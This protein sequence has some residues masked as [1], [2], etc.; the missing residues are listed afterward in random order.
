MERNGV[1]KSKNVI[2]FWAIPVEDEII[3]LKNIIKSLSE[4]L[5]T[6]IFLPHITIY[7][8][9]CKASKA[10]TIIDNISTNYNAFNIKVKR[11]DYSDEITK[12]LYIDFYES[13]SLTRIYNFIKA[14]LITS[15]D[16]LLSPH[17]SLVYKKIRHKTQERLSK[18]ISIP[19]PAIHFDEVMIV[20][21]PRYM[22][23]PLDIVSWNII[24]S[25]KLLK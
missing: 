9:Y 4:K 14:Q 16:Y 21:T 12:T 20:S 10:V 23:S 1:L 5:K 7:A 6:P 17:L 8:G 3:I 19:M 22:K 24:Y 13:K 18:E 25:Q 2:S 11:I 15:E